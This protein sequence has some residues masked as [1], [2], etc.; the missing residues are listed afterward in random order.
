MKAGNNTT[1]FDF[2]TLIIIIN[3]YFEIAINN[4]ANYL[5]SL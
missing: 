4:P 2:L 5:S 1:L 3:N